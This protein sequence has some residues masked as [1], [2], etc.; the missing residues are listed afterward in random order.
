MM[1]EML[2]GSSYPTG[3]KK[4]M[5]LWRTLIANKGWNEKKPTDEDWL[6]YKAFVR[7]YPPSWAKESSEKRIEDPELRRKSWPFEKV[8]QDVQRGRQFGITTCGHMGI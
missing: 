8:M 4:D 5:V 6:S 1:T 3:E 7:S 2:L